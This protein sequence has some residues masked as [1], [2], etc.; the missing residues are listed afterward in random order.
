MAAAAF[1]LLLLALLIQWMALRRARR[2]ATAATLAASAGQP[3]HVAGSG[4][5]SYVGSG[6]YAAQQP[7]AAAFGG[8]GGLG[9]EEDP[10]ADVQQTAF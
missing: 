2:D 9:A 7:A 5:G 8:A 3:L 10:F 1:A 4:A 6:P